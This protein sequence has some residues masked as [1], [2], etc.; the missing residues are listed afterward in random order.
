ML[1]AVDF[2]HKEMNTVIKAIIDLAEVRL[3]AN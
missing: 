1:G 2:G 3:G